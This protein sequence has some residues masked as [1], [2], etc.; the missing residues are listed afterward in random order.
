MP[1]QRTSFAS[2]VRA[3]AHNHRQML[4]NGLTLRRNP[5]SCNQ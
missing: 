5:L 1:G 2:L 4:T 3:T